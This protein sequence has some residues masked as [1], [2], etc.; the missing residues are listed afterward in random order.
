MWE[1]R[2]FIKERKRRE[3]EITKAKNGKWRSEK[4]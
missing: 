4:S 3:R 2:E 1:V